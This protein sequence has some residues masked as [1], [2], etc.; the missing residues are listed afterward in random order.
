MKY[1]L[2]TSFILLSSVDLHSQ[3]IDLRSWVKDI[4]HENKGLYI[5]IDSIPEDSLYWL[6]KEMPAEWF[7]CKA[8]YAIYKQEPSGVI[9]SYLH[10]L[11]VYMEDEASKNIPDPL[12]KKMEKKIKDWLYNATADELSTSKKNLKQS[13]QPVVQPNTWAKSMETHFPS[14]WQGLS[15]MSN[16]KEY[17]GRMLD[18]CSVRYPL[19][20]ALCRDKLV[21]SLGIWNDIEF[22]EFEGGVTVYL[23]D[24][25]STTRVINRKA[26]RIAFLV[27][28][29]LK[30]EQQSIQKIEIEAEYPS[31]IW[32]DSYSDLFYKGADVILN[33]EYFLN[34]AVQQVTIPSGSKMKNSYLGLI[35]LM[36]IGRL[37]RLSYN[38]GLNIPDPEYR[39][40]TNPSNPSKKISIQFIFK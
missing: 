25:D 11:I 10:L 13:S 23:N 36:K 34:G 18:E 21:D 2:F 27:E 16:N 3:K 37:F 38:D 15:M 40:T 32:N 26:P 30:S 14:C 12:I 35:R 22:S 33:Q 28:Q 19:T 8:A 24:E 29:F 1:F 6:K 4:V 20:K 31:Q 5:K 7:F 39:V 17:Q 9:L